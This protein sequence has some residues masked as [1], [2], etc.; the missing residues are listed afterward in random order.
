MKDFL[1]F[2]AVMALSL[3]PSLLKMVKKD[4]QQTNRTPTPKPKPEPYFPDAD[5][6]KPSAKTR[7]RTYT[8]V[9]QKDDY[10][11]YETVPD[12]GFQSDLTASDHDGK[13]GLQTASAKAGSGMEDKG[14]PEIS[15]SESEIYKGIIYSEILKRKYI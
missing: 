8:P 1:I 7:A 6:E 3:V 5:Q 11:T 10:F 9:D 15:L 2:L 14:K 13:E 4:L 12:E